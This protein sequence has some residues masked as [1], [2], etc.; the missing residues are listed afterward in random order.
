MVEENKEYYD[1][2][3]IMNAIPHRYPFLLVDRVTEINE[4]GG[5]GYR[6]VTI[7]DSCFQGHF[8]GRPVY[9]G[10]LII[11]G[12]AQCAGVIAFK[13]LEKQIGTQGI[14]DKLIFFATINNVKFREIVQPGDQL[15]YDIEISQ[16]TPSRGK[17]S[18][19]ALVNGKVVC[20]AEMIA[21]LRDK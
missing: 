3:D 13:K 4:K 6:N 20:E 8:P 11:E 17:F 12:M 15:F 2:L 19:K 7:N 18:G 9:P 16:L 10:V 21:V 1:I 5:K 14:K